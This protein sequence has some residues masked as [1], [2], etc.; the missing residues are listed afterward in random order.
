MKKIIF[1]VIVFMT[2]LSSSHAYSIFVV[3][4][5]NN[6]M[7]YED[8][9]INGNYAFIVG[10]IQDNKVKLNNLAYVARLRNDIVYRATIQMKILEES[11]GKDYHL[12]DGINV[13]DTKE[14]EKII[15]QYLKKY[16]ETN[17]CSGKSY[18]A[19]YKEWITL[20]C[21]VSLY[22]YTID[23]EN[24]ILGNNSQ[25]KPNAGGRQVVNFKHN[26]LNILNNYIFANKWW[27]RDFSITLNVAANIVKFNIITPDNH[28]F[29]FDYG[30]YDESD[31]LIEKVTLKTGYN[32]IYFAK[33]TNVYLKEITEYPIYLYDE[34]K[35]L[36]VS[37]DIYVMD[38]VKEPREFNVNINTYDRD[39]YY[40]DSFI[41]TYT[42]VTIY[43]QNY[44][45]YTTLKCDEDCNINLKTGT[46]IFE[47]NVS[48]FRELWR[49][50]GDME[51]N[52][53]RY[54]L[55]G[56]KCNEEITN[57]TKDNESINF[58]KRGIMYIFDEV[59]TSGIY[60]ITIGGKK[61]SVNLSNYNNY[62]YIRNIG[63]LYE[64]EI[65]IGNDNT[66]EV[67]DDIVVG[68]FL[69]EYDN[70]TVNVPDTY[71]S[72]IESDKYVLFKKKYNYCLFNSYSFIN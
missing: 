30:I 10:D 5:D 60:E 18:N 6:R 46:Y 67:V 26:S 64:L 17:S 52:M 23:N 62:A 70:I 12:T 22:D 21:G 20:S 13:I 48:K 37:N 41:S 65:D 8:Y 29:L 7:V 19:S 9:L 57:I 3:D 42:D 63:T 55:N 61:Y 58:T 50:E 54:L 28:D 71:I 68:D 39:M 11:N 40:D 32:E 16:E 27:Y 45:Y 47:D 56:I 15:E 53:Y 69:P 44:N 4:E 14:E 33:G 35:F 59:M 72:T 49:I 31:N 36:K 51:V 66:E 24:V 25:I 1:M 34:D 2:F 38:V 43:D